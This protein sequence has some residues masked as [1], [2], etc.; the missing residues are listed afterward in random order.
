MNKEKAEPLQPGQITNPL[1]LKGG[2]KY[3]LPEERPERD[4]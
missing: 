4:G 1:P 2:C 3:M